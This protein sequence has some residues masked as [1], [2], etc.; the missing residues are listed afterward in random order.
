[1]LTVGGGRRRFRAERFRK[2]KD[3]A[4]IAAERKHRLDLDKDQALAAKNYKEV[5]LDLEK[6]RKFDNADVRKAR[7]LDLAKE[8]DA[9]KNVRFREGGGDFWKRQF[10]DD[11]ESYDLGQSRFLLSWTETLSTDSIRTSLAKQAR[12]TRSILHPS[13]RP[14]IPTLLPTRPLLR[15]LLLLLRLPT[16]RTTTLPLTPE[17]TR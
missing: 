11:S 12:T 7:A 14:T 2:N 6:D 16:T 8:K 3:K 15:L 17:S 10:D 9:R 5:N 1:V 13:P 4:L